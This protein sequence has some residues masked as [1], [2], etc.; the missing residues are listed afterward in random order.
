MSDKVK[1]ATIEFTAEE[2]ESVRSLAQRKNKRAD[3]TLL[4]PPN[5]LRLALQLET[6]K[7]GGARLNTGNRNAKGPRS[8]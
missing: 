2:W 3:L 7:R 4:T 5:I 6:K 1:I 8:A